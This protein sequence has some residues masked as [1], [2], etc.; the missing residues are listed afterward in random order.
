MSAA[1]ALDGLQAYVAA[2]ERIAAKL[3]GDDA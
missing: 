2:H 1:P 3:P